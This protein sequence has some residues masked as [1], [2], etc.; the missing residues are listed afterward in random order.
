LLQTIQIPAQ[1][2]A[3]TV[4]AIS[5]ALSTP[6]VPARRNATD[7]LT[8][9]RYN[10]PEEAIGN[11]IEVGFDNLSANAGM[12][13]RY[14]YWF[15]SFLDTLAG[16]GRMGSMVGASDDLRRHGGHESSLNEYAVGSF[17]ASP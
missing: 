3:S 15:K 14:D 7:L 1:T 8:F 12:P 13:G 6:Y 9:M 16:R 4:A 11:S 5:S 2:L 17:S 10:I